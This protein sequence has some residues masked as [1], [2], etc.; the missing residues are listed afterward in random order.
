M[1]GWVRMML[2]SSGVSAP[3]LF[4]ML[5]GML[6]L[7]MSFR[8]D[9]VVMRRIFYSVRPYTTVFSVSMRSSISVTVCT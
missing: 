4:R 5:S 8:A 1:A 9:A 3:A 6:I 2:N 7:P